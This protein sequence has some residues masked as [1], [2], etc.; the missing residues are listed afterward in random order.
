M[1]CSALGAWVT[2]CRQNLQPTIYRRFIEFGDVPERCFRLAV[3]YNK[4]TQAKDPKTRTMT[5]LRA[6]CP[7]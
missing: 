2:S 3:L 1:V 6:L 5:E 7:R 4:W